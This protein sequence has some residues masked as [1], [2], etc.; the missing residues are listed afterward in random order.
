MTT[1]PLDQARRHLHAASHHIH[2]APGSELATIRTAHRRRTRGRTLTCAAAALAVGGGTFVAIQQLGKT[3]PGS[4]STSD[5]PGAT[6]PDIEFAPPATRTPATEPV[7]EV[8]A[9]ATPA[10]GAPTGTDTVLTP[11]VPAE[12]RYTWAAITPAAA[13]AVSGFW[14]GRFP[15]V[16]L[17]TAPGRVDDTAPGAYDPVPYYSADG[18][19]FERL[20]LTIPGDLRP[21][22]AA[23]DSIYAIGTAPGI[24]ATEPNPLRAV[25]STDRGA[26]W[27]TFVL[28]VDA[29]APD[30]PMLATGVAASALPIEAGVAVIVD[31][32]VGIDHRQL[33]AEWRN[34]VVG[35]TDAG[36][37]VRDDRD[38]LPAPVATI[39]PSVEGGLTATATTPADECSTTL[40]TW[41]QIGVPAESVAALAAGHSTRVFLVTA[42]GPVEI[43]LPDGMRHVS[44]HPDARESIFYMSATDGGD[45]VYELLADGSWHRLDIPPLAG[46]GGPLARSD[47]HA[48]MQAYVERGS[49]IGVAAAGSA[50]AYTDLAPLFGEFKLADTY[51]LAAGPDGMAGITAV[52]DDEVAAA[53][54]QTITVDDATMHRD[55][56]NQDPYF[57]DETTGEVV[58]PE[59]VRPLREPRAD[60]VVLEILAADGS[61]LA[62]FTDA[63]VHGL[64]IWDDT[65]EW[66]VTTSEDGVNVAVESIADLLGVAQS[67]I[68]SVGPPRV[69]G[70]QLVLPVLTNETNPDGS[71]VQRLLVGTPNE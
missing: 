17:A 49:A 32:Y 6:S 68:R 13:E 67:D 16:V 38:C 27:N 42:R 23:G 60:G 66:Y 58:P 54:G 40:M 11:A 43:E 25:V 9:S 51:S 62:G 22:V 55:R 63:Q 35:Q 65:P 24:A 12:S 19:T 10:G 39:A 30:P 71:P 50:W 36:L 20:D 48:F 3:S 53:G 29:A 7:V 46:H 45:E 57:V 44:S 69:I 37:Q 21:V 34:R 4:F 47:T 2:L 41:E 5:E 59:R 33:P 18:V 31:E 52:R 8:P 70:R 26:T 64:E 14:Q 56:A 1:D 28:P 15:G 61:V